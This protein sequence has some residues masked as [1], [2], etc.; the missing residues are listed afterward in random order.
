MSDLTIARRYAQALAETASAEGKLDAVDADVE[1][2]RGLM[3]S[4]RDLML[5]LDSPIISR[6]KK[7]EVMEGVFKDKVEPVTRRFMRSMPIG[8]RCAGLLMSR[9]ASHFRCRTPTRRPFRHRSIA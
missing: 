9:P 3:A 2:I 1:A 8:M 6:E 7:A 4:S 5:F